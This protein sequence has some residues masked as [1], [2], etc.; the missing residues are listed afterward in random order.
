[1]VSCL[2]LNIF[3]T[4]CV[5]VSTNR[6]LRACVASVLFFWTTITATAAPSTPVATNPNTSA[7]IATSGRCAGRRAGGAVLRDLAAGVVLA[8]TGVSTRTAVDPAALPLAGPAG[9]DAR[10][11]TACRG[12]VGVD[13]IRSASDKA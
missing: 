9:R 8:E 5:A 10:R 7:T 12:R 4:V 11:R 2:K 13:V 3:T 1:M 6:W